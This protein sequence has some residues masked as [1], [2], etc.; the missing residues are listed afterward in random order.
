LCGYRRLP[1]LATTGFRCS[2]SSAVLRR[3]PA[4]PGCRVLPDAPT[5]AEAGFENIDARLQWIGAFTATGTPPAIARKLEAAIRQAPLIQ[6][7][8]ELKAVAYA[9]DGRSG[10]EFRQLID[11]DIK[12]YADVVRAANLKFD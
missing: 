4:A 1:G 10:E 12:A 11:A 2:R 5:A 8:D 7:C 9:P 6:P 3:E